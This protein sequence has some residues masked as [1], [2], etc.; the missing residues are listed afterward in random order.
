MR[1]NDPPIHEPADVLPCC[2]EGFITAAVVITF[3]S[4]VE[5]LQLP[6]AVGPLQLSFAPLFHGALQH[7]ESWPALD[8]MSPAITTTHKRHANHSQ[9]VHMLGFG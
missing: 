7:Q 9:I 1:W 6:F 8:K 4:E 2:R 5:P 3:S